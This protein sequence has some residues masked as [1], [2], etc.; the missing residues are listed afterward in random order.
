MNLSFSLLLS[1][2]SLVF[3]N[4]LRDTSFYGLLTHEK[5]LRSQ[6]F[7][8]LLFLDHCH[9]TRMM[10]KTLPV[11]NTTRILILFFLLFIASTVLAVSFLFT[12]S[13]LFF[14]M[15]L[16]S[17]PCLDAFGL[18][19]A[20]GRRI[21]NS[22]RIRLGYCVIGFTRYNKIILDL[23]VLVTASTTSLSTVRHLARLWYFNF[24]L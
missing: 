6:A 22:S 11:L 24:K 16:N 13:S 10:N 12:L 7:F 5:L 23:F 15:I 1:L 18:G 8:S 9:V 4:Q 17:L 2:A 19:K 14:K 21:S 3:S 20:T